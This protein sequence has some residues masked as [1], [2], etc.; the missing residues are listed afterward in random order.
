M[1]ESLPILNTDGQGAG[2]MELKQSWIE[3]EK[4]AQ[5]VHDT[6]VAH[7]AQ[8][9]AGTASTKTRAEVRGGG[10]KPYVQ[11]GTGRA[12]A[13]SNRSPI[14]GGGGVIFGPK[15]RKYR[16]KVNKKVKRLAL[17]R[18]FSERINDDEVVILD[19]CDLSEPK[20]KNFVKLMDD[21]NLPLDALVVVDEVSRN[22]RLATRNIPAVDVTT[23]SSVD[24]YSMMLFRKV[25]F[26]R[27][28]FDNFVQRISPEEA[29]N[30]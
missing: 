27:A 7:L 5:A 9:R 26:S 30:E 29:E 19:N 13:G 17:K 8:R 16:K 1:K 14:W 6:V 21:C 22:L 2:E 3:M 4:G 24:T 23:A 20:T 18:A 15:P 11:K 28:G 10:A 25:I 12:R